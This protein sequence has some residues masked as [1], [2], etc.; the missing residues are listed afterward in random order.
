[1]WPGGLF[2]MF[3]V[4]SSSSSSPIPQNV[5]LGAESF[6]DGQVSGLQDIKA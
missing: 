1:V 2:V 5:L 3:L 4:N 6:L